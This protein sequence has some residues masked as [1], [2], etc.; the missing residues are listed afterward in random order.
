MFR[1]PLLAGNA[2]SVLKR[3]YSIVL[4]ESTAKSLFGTANAVGKVLRFDNKSDLTVTGILKNIPSSSSLQFDFLVPFAH[5]EATNEY[6]K[7]SRTGGSGENGF[8]I[9]VKLQPGFLTGR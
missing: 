8:Q 3:P 4:T 2:G 6:V 1:Y 7:R 9:F 5:L